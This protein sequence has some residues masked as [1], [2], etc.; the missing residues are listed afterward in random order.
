VN[1]IR[2]PF[3]PTVPTARPVA[4]ARAA[5]FQAVRGAQA[6]TPAAPTQQQA[7]QALPTPAVTP[8]QSQASPAQ[9]QRYLRP[10]SIVDIKV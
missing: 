4:D 9:P 10:G 5:F 2:P 7:R 8:V 1:P 3:A 6:A